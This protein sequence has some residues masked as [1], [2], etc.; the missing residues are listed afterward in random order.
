MLNSESDRCTFFRIVRNECRAKLRTV[1]Y[2]AVFLPFLGLPSA[3]QQL[4]LSLTS[5][6][7]AA[8]GNVTLSLSLASVSNQAASLEWTV[9][10][11]AADI[12]AVSVVPAGSASAKQVQCNS[13]T[14]STTCIVAGLNDDAIPSGIVANVAFQLAANPVSSVI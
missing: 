6:T 1:S 10:Y 12:T 5:A 7:G 3:A 2:L 8:G 9:T 4:G 14:G 11:S 13:K